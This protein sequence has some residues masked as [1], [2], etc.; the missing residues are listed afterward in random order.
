MQKRGGVDANPERGVEAESSLR[1]WN[2]SEE[3]ESFLAKPQRRGSG[4]ERLEKALPS[5]ARG[6]GL[7]F[8]LRLPL[9]LPFHV[10][11]SG[12]KKTVA[13]STSSTGFPTRDPFQVS[14]AWTDPLGPMEVFLQHVQKCE[15]GKRLSCLLSHFWGGWGTPES[16]RFGKCGDFVARS[17]ARPCFLLRGIVQT[18]L[19]VP[20]GRRGVGFSPGSPGR[21]EF[22]R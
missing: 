1:T 7:P 14:S 5:K 15:A 2:F 3:L 17:I 4:S 18:C 8:R 10:L 22:G 6:G 13:D 21:R 11:R 20:G 12:G 19:R 9:R 16:N